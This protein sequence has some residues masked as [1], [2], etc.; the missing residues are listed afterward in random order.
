MSKTS[1]AE[2]RANVDA[3]EYTLVIS[4]VIPEGSAANTGYRFDEARAA[5]EAIGYGSVAPMAGNMGKC[6]ICGANFR[7][8][9]I[10]RH[11]PTGALTHIGHECADKLELK[12][13]PEAKRAIA[14]ARAKI[15]T[16]KK[17]AKGHA[18]MRERTLRVRQF[19]FGA[20]PGLESALSLNNPRAKA[21]GATLDEYDALSVDEIA[22]AVARVEK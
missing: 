15:K 21:I 1:A 9:D 11:M 4:Y 6:A 18:N 5:C 8:G 20:Y 7:V 13:E 3:S 2:R 14:R 12:V 16:A 17:A 19:Y 10:F 22:E